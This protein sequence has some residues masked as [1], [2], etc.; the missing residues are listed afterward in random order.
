MKEPC[1]LLH[2]SNP[3]ISSSWLSLQLQAVSHCWHYFL[4]GRLWVWPVEAS[5]SSSCVFLLDLL[6][7]FSLVCLFY[8]LYRVSHCSQDWPGTVTHQSSCLS[9]PSKWSP[10]ECWDDR[11]GSRLSWLHFSSTA[12]PLTWAVQAHLMLFLKPSLDTFS[13]L[14]GQKPSTWTSTLYTGLS[15]YNSCCPQSANSAQIQTLQLECTYGVCI[16]GYIH[17]HA[18]TFT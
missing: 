14:S 5:S 10:G 2:L 15:S 7:R 8:G 13:K 9:L 12:S 17:T 4:C 18:H 6:L 1:H 3:N 16:H 11:C